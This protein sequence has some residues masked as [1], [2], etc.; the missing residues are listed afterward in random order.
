MYI[1]QVD[2]D[3]WLVILGGLRLSWLLCI[4]DT[5]ELGSIYTMDVACSKIESACFFGV[6]GLTYVFIWG[7][8]ARVLPLVSKESPSCHNDNQLVT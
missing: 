6:T 4:A 7:L 5:M 8:D 1:Y 3:V 2:Q